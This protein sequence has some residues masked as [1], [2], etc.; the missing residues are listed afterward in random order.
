MK[1]TLILALG[2]LLTASIQGKDVFNVKAVVRSADVMR[3]VYP[4]EP[5]VYLYEG[6]GHFGSSYGPLGLHL[7]PSQ[8]NSRYGKTHFLHLEHMGRGKFAHDYLIPMMEIYWQNLPTSVTDYSQNQNYYDGIVT[9]RFTADGHSLSVRTWFD[10]VEKNLAAVDVVSQKGGE[11]IV[12]APIAQPSIHYDQHPRQEIVLR[13]ERED[14]WHISL[15]CLGKHSEVFLHTNADVHQED[16]NLVLSLRKGQNYLLISYGQDTPTTLKQSERQSTH[17]WHTAWQ[18]LGGISVTDLHAQQTWVRSMAMFLSSYDDT[19]KGLGPPMGFTGNWWPF[20]YPQDVSYVHPILLQTGNLSIARSW[21]EEWA[22]KADGLRQYTKRLYGVDGLLA[23]WV[24]PYGSFE[25][26]HDPT[27][28]NKFFYEIHNS[29]YFCRMAAETAV[30][31]DD[32]DWTRRYAAPIIAGTAEFYANICHKQADGLWHLFVRPSM[33]QDERGGE[34]QPDYLCALYSA[35]YCFQQAI[36]FGLDPEGRYAQILQDGLAFES[37]RSSRGYY[38]SSAGSGEKDFGHQKH[39]V[40]LNELAF[41]PVNE[42]PSAPALLVYNLR[43]D[44]TADARRPHFY[45]WTLGEFLLAGS[46]VGEV[47]QWQTD[48][49]NMEASEYVDPEWIQIYETSR[50]LTTP[51]YNIT[52]GLVAQSLLSNLVSD[53]YGRLELGKCNP[54]QGRVA[55]RRI[56][57]GLGVLVDGTFQDSHY[58]VTLTA[59]RDC[60]FALDGQQYSLRRGQRVRVRR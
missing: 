51:F 42:Q 34:N 52:N 53:W 10:A 59:W 43:Y 33:G 19:H 46:R 29:G 9:T 22:K 13:Q 31:V 14:V 8:R 12:V 1:R 48:W 37:L 2:V 27:P 60:Q 7:H 20:Y 57:T 58:D 45:G 6:N 24:Y 32:P 11:C 47:G 16:E 3:T 35:Q 28:P 49:A 56:R 30:H 21:I 41:L 40:Q 17:W 15:T 54:W 18:E 5:T 36:R 4:T 26:Y 39:P 38:Y 25:G 55:V 44:I 23:P 50:N